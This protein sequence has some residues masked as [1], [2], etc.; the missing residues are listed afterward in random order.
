MALSY[1]EIWCDCQSNKMPLIVFRLQSDR[2]HLEGLLRHLLLN[3][4]SRF[5][6]SVVGTE[7]LFC[8]HILRWCCCWSGRPHSE[9][10]SKRNNRKKWEIK[11]QKLP[12]GSELILG[13]K[14]WIGFWTV[15]GR[16]IQGK[17]NYRS[18]CRT[19]V[20]LL[21]FSVLSPARKHQGQ[22]IKCGTK[23][24]TWRPLHQPYLWQILVLL[25]PFSRFSFLYYV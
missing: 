5:N 23:L 21:L 13:P 25:V 6:G 16:T 3:L 4:I 14:E 2:N 9:N 22:L 20:F 17:R 19:V 12:P 10:C 11:H 24:P 1:R 15:K 7:E 8:S 18:K